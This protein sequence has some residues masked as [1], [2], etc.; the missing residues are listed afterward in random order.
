MTGF[1]LELLLRFTHYD[2]VATPFH[3]PMIDPDQLRPLID[4]VHQDLRPQLRLESIHPHNPVKVHYLPTPWI[5]LGT[6]NYAAVVSHP[7][8]PE[9]AIKIYAPTRPGFAEEVE[10][11]RRLGIHPAFSQCFYAHD[12]L[13]I[14]KRLRGVTLYDC[15]HRGLRIPKQVIADI[16]QALDYARGQGLNPRDIHGKNVMMADDRG[17]VVDISDFLKP[18]S[19]AVWWDFKR[20]Y[21]WI[22]RPLLS[23]AKIPIPL[24]LLDFS[25]FVYRGLRALFQRQ[26]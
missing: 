19:G 14:L 11:Y 25:R 3:P 9:H 18:G 2:R 7:D 5:L 21:F 20:F 13:L 6:G 1:R 24:K 16:D 10:V 17:F 26:A 8:Y 23:P 22:Y 4:L 15:L 12:G